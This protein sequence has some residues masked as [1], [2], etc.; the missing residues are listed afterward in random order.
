MSKIRSEHPF[1]PPAVLL[2]ELGITQPSELVI[3]AI[4]QHCGATIIYEPLD[5][6]QARILGFGNRA[7]ITVNVSSPPERR[8]FSAAHELGHWMRDRGKVAFACTDR[9]FVREWGDDNPERAA[10][11]FAAALLL[12][13]QMFKIAAVSKP[14]TFA[15][16]RDLMSTF[17]MSRTATAIRLI[18]LTDL[19]AMITCYDQSK[20]LWSWRS[21]TVPGDFMPV[22]QL[23]DGSVAA[24]LLANTGRTEPGPTVVDANEWIDRADSARHSVIEDSVRAGTGTVL[25][26]LWWKDES[27][28]LNAEDADDDDAMTGV[29]SFGS[30]KRR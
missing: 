15:T 11:R 1:K 24:T 30:R 13:P 6:C 18:E 28:I 17:E 8:R 5:G 29:L 14:P 27:Q 4:A 2:K 23:G 20:R 22:Q 19:P 3:E 25:S 10:N 7:I 12:P 21:S 16:V 26:L 9:A